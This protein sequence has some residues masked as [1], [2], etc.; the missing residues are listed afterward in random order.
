M[1]IQI[2]ETMP[3][4]TLRTMTDDG[5]VELNT[6]E[7]FKGKR[8][9]LFAVPAA[10]TPGCSQI[11]LKSYVDEAQAITAKG[12]DVIACVAVHDAWVMDAWADA[13]GAKGTVTM[14]ADGNADYVTALG[15]NVD[16]SAHGLGMRSARFSM[17]INDGVVES[18]NI[19]ERAI[20]STAATHTC[21]L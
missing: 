11:H 5:V 4:G 19:D 14:L 16:L 18:L 9:A 10:F 2:G 6:T 17:V 20:D 21:G 15:L 8:V 1:T 12:F 3:S 7:I 13:Y